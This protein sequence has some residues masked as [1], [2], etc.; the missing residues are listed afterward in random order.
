M[1]CNATC[2]EDSLPFVVLVVDDNPINRKVLTIPLRKQGIQVVEAE[3]GLEAV[4]RYAQ[5]R[6]ALVLMDIS[7]PIMDGFEATRQIRMHEQAQST[8]SSDFVAAGALDEMIN[9][10]LTHQRARIVAATTHSADRDFDEGKQAGMDDWLLK[11]IRPSVLVQDILEY[12]RNHLQEFMATLGAL[13]VAGIG[14]A[15]GETAVE[16]VMEQAAT[17]TATAAATIA[18]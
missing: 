10:V 4:Q 16:T 6:P 3:N 2:L 15:A 17:P 14:V 1:M 12:R 9:M 18:A 11:P 7:M 13:G 5:I 8:S